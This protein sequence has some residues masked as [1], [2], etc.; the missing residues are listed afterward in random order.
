[1]PDL[2][3]SQLTTTTDPD[4]LLVPGAR[5]GSNFELDLG[6]SARLIGQ[7]GAGIYAVASG[8]NTYTCAFTPVFTSFTTGQHVFVNFT[9]INTGPATLN[10]SGGGAVTIVKNKNAALVGA[11]LLGIVE[12]VYDGTNLQ[13]VNSNKKYYQIELAFNVAFAPN[14]ITTYYF[15]FGLT[16]STTD[17]HSGPNVPIT[18]VV[19]KALLSSRANGTVTTEDSTIIL[20]ANGGSVG[21]LTTDYKFGDGAGNNLIA[22]EKTGLS[23]DISEGQH[24]SIRWNTPGW[25]TNP[26]NTTMYIILLVRIL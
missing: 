12:L 5:S 21:N 10:P 1:M 2:K 25:A 18:G 14:D 3:I 26:T 23:L 7:L 19:E 6:A 15:S 4:G 11:E 17:L 9:N 8:T 13:I 20:Y 16:P 22:Q 24:L